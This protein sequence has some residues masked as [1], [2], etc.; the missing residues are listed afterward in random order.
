MTAPLYPASQCS[1]R[2]IRV[3]I[4]I[5]GITRPYDGL[6]AANAGADAIGLVFHPSSPRAVTVEQALDI[7]RALPPFVTCVGLFANQPEAVIRSTLDRVPLDLLQ[8]HGEEPAAQ[9]RRYGKP[10]LK[11]L[12]VRAGLDV[13]RLCALYEDA[14]GWL[15]DS[16]VPGKQGGTGVA[17]EWSLIPSGL[18][19]PIVLAGGLTPDNVAQAIDCVHPYGVDVS[20]GVESAKG[21]KD[22]DKMHRFIRSVWDAGVR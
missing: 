19:R 10:Y 14:V 16:F 20:G 4:K 2:H 21:I 3:R 15:M 9:C 11:A 13:R 7:V 1:P 8:F 12:R 22:E 5:C 17:F 6:A 18:G